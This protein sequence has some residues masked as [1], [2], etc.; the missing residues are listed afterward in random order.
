MQQKSQ[1]ISNETLLNEMKAIIEQE[2]AHI[3]KIIVEENKD[4]I[5]VNKIILQK[6]RKSI[7]QKEDKFLNETILPLTYD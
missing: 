4:E 3:K 5:E 7:I 6:P 2:H 1:E